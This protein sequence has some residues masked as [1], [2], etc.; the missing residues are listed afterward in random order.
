VESQLLRRD[1]TEREA[2]RLRRERDGAVD[3]LSVLYAERWAAPLEYSHAVRSGPLQVLADP[4]QGGWRFWARK[5]EDC[6][7][8]V[9]NIERGQL[10]LVWD[11]DTEGALPWF[12]R[13]LLAGAGAIAF[14]H[15]GARRVLLP[16]GDDCAFAGA[17]VALRETP[18]GRLVDRRAYEQSLG[19]P[20]PATARRPRWRFHPDYHDWARARAYQKA[21]RKGKR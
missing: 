16:S 18:E 5:A 7:G 21:R 10:S 1:L 11:G 8:L 12:R 19:L 9:G 15:L 17:G 3:E 6:P 4:H 20:R 14:E 13:S 2:D